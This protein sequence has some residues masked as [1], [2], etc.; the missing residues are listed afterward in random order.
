MMLSWHYLMALLTTALLLSSYEERHRVLPWDC[1]ADQNALHARSASSCH[2]VGQAL[3][4]HV[5]FGLQLHGAA[6]A[7]RAP[8]PA[9]A[10]PAMDLLGLDDLLGG[11]SLAPA[12]TPQPQQP[13]PPP[14]LQLRPQPQLSPQVFQQK[15]GTLTNMTKF[16]HSL[17]SSA[18]ALVE[19]NKHQVCHLH[20]RLVC[21]HQAVQLIMH[22]IFA[23]RSSAK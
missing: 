23:H 3:L 9:P 10:P 15:W 22:R 11:T 19:A 5:V 18:M 4:L 1:S 6:A 2:H 21:W 14:P 12:P 7:P 20:Y 13:P 17:T 16:Q 8:S